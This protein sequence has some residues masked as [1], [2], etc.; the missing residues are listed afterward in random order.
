MSN[1]NIKPEIQKPSPLVEEVHFFQ[2]ILVA[3]QEPFDFLTPSFYCFAPARR[4]ESLASAG[5]TSS[6]GCRC[7]GMWMLQ[8]WWRLV[9]LCS[10][11]LPLLFLLDFK[12]LNVN[13]RDL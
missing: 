6:L 1:L 13:S 9:A 11:L 5:C 2:L 3:S 8:P 7:M 4:A 10:I 12:H